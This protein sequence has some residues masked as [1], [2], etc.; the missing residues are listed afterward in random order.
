[1]PELQ[2]LQRVRG[3]IARIVEHYVADPSAQD[4]AER[5]PQH[6]VVVVVDGQWRRTGP[7]LL[8]PD[9]RA[10]IEPAQED[11][12]DIGKRIPANGEGPEADE[13]RVDGGKR[14]DVKRHR[15]IRTI[16]RSA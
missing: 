12:D 16:L 5:H 3:E 2:A 7:Q 9:D 8:A 11:A 10:R 15:A 14:D 13:H 4:D 6:E 1:M